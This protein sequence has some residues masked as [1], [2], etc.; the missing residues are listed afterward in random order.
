MVVLPAPFAVVFSAPA[1]V[2]CPTATVVVLPT[3][4]VCFLLAPS[5]VVLPAVTVVVLPAMLWLCC[6]L[7]LRLFCMPTLTV[8]VCWSNNDCSA[9]SVSCLFIYCIVVAPVVYLPIPSA[10]DLLSSTV[11][12]PGSLTGVLPVPL[13]VPLFQPCYSWLLQL[14]VGHPSATV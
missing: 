12:F 2:I 9:C 8:F 4:I 11:V 5:A 6:V 10:N 14:A 3:H 1:T 7:L 13:F